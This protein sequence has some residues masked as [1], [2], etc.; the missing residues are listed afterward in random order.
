MEDERFEFGVWIS[1]IEGSEG[2]VDAVPRGMAF[3]WQLAQERP[4]LV[5]PDRLKNL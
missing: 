3:T 5:Q 2:L 1:E 4:A